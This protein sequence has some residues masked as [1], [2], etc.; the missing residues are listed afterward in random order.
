MPEA[1]PGTAAGV[2]AE[3]RVRKKG[4]SLWKDAW[5]RLKKN[6]FAMG[7]LIVMV[8][9]TIAAVIAP[10]ITPMPPDYGQPWLRTARAPGF[11]HPAVLAE[12]RFDKGEAPFVPE[13][14]PPVIADYLSMTAPSPTA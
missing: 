6:K 9:V 3:V 13:R 2:A 12:I 8:V 5:R 14:I 4:Q 7:G 11:E 1:V 10:W